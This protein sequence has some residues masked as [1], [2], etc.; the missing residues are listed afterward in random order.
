[1]SKRFGQWARVAV[2]AAAV[3]V[4][5]VAQAEV[6]VDLETG[7]GFVGKGDVQLG[8]GWNNKALQDCVGMDMPTGCLSFA[9][10]SETT[11]VTEVSWVCTNSNNQHLQERARTTTTSS[12]LQ[13]VFSATGRVKNQVTGFNLTGFDGEPVVVSSS[14]T[15]GQ[16]LNS[17]PSGPWVLT[18][19]AGEPEVIS[20]E[21]SGTFLI[22]TDKRDQKSIEIDLSPAVVE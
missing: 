12:S 16:P 20:S 17:C 8:F 19:P 18:S 7:Q 22:V 15:E 4:A 1:M 21:G 9:I 2:A 13:G 6:I 3:A 5:G 14:E 10:E 11:V